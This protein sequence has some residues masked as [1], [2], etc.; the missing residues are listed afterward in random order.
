MEIHNLSSQAEIAGLDIRKLWYDIREETE[1][2]D[3]SLCRQDGSDFATF[4]HFVAGYDVAY[5]SYL[6]YV[7]R[8]CDDT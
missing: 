6:W 7:Y 1:G 4:H 5:Y 8:S 2:M 3:F